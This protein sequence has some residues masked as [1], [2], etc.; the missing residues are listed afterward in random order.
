MA[1]DTIPLGRSVLAQMQDGGQVLLSRM[2]V[3][4]LPLDQVDRPQVS[5]PEEFMKKLWRRLACNDEAVAR[6]LGF[7]HRPGL[8]DFMMELEFE[9]LEFN[10]DEGASTSED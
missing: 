9:P 7:A 8:D 3:R 4:P 1:F 10:G 6:S 2:R 5:P